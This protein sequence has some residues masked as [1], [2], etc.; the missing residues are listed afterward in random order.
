MGNTKA[1]PLF[2][3]RGKTTG[4]SLPFEQQRIQSCVSTRKVYTEHCWGVND[5]LFSR[6]TAY[7]VG[8]LCDEVLTK[9][10]RE[11]ERSFFF[12]LGGD[13]TFSGSYG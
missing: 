8:Q 13:Q 4:G 10:I 11:R 12:R 1:L 2:L 9:D 3:G 6:S 7:G 5:A